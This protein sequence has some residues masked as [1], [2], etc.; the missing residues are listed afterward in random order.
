MV[1]LPQA[2]C[3][4]W[5]SRKGPAVLATVGQESVPNVIY[6]GCVSKF[7]DETLLV[8]DNYFCKT[9]ENIKDGSRAAILFMAKDG[10]SYQV[11]GSVEYHTDGELFENMKGWNPKQHPGHAAMALKVD[12]VYAGADKLA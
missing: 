1:A 2:V 4:G 8:A 11:K 12:E 7:D 10:T 5:D 6:V 3:D 9:R